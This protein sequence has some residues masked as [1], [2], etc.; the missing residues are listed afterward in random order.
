MRRP[1]QSGCPTRP[2]YSR[3]V[4]PHAGFFCKD[5]VEV[6]RQ[7][8]LIFTL[9]LGPFLILMLFGFGFRPAP[10]TLR[11]VLVVPEG[12]GL[13]ERSEELAQ[14]LGSRV[15]LIATTGN[16]QD[17]AALLASGDADVMV[18][19]PGDALETVRGNERAKISCT[20]RPD[21]PVRKFVHRLVC[22]IRG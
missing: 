13:A 8:R 9:V 4:D 7:P 11:T 20:P 16:E 6:L 17:G 21:R 14:T 10:P 18:V 22:P 15:S 12:S 1:N 5:V 3:P 2:Q 19:I